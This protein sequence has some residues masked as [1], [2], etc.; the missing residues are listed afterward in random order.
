[1]T[2]RSYLLLRRAILVGVVSSI[3]FGVGFLAYRTGTSVPGTEVGAGKMALVLMAAV[4]AICGYL[5][6]MFRLETNTGYSFA[7]TPRLFRSKGEPGF[8]GQEDYSELVERLPDG[9]YPREQTVPVNHSNPVKL[10]VHGKGLAGQINMAANPPA[11]LGEDAEVAEELDALARRYPVVSQLLSRGHR[12]AVELMDT[13]DL[14]RTE[15]TSHR[16]PDGTV[17]KLHVRHAP[18]LVGMVSHA[19]GL[20]MSFAPL[21]GQDEGLWK[22][23]LGKMS[24]QLGITTLEVRQDGGRMVLAFNDKI[25]DLK[26]L[27]KL[28]EPLRVQVSQGHFRSPLGVS[29]FGDVAIDWANN[30][31]MVA[32]GVPG[33]GKT[34]SMLPVFAGL[35][36]RVEMHIADGKLSEDLRSMIPICRTFDNEGGYELGR[37]YALC[38]SIMFMINS[39]AR[40]KAIY[41]SLGIANFWNADP[42]AREAAGLYPIFVNIDECQFWFDPGKTLSK[43][44]KAA[45]DSIINDVKNMIQRGRSLGIMVVLTTQKP[46][47]DTIPTSIRDIAGL[48]IAFRVTTRDQGKAI[49]GTLSSD[50]ASPIAI[51]KEIKGRCVMDVEG[52]GSSL[53]QTNYIDPDEIESWLSNNFAPVPDQF[54]RAVGYP[55]AVAMQAFHDG[56]DPPPPMVAGLTPEAGRMAIVDDDMMA[57]MSSYDAMLDAPECTSE[58][59][60]MLPVSQPPEPDAE[61]EE[62][63]AAPLPEGPPAA[64][65]TAPVPAESVRPAVEPREQTPAAPAPPHDRPSVAGVLP[66]A[67]PE[68][69]KSSAPPDSYALPIPAPEVPR[70]PPPMPPPAG[71]AYPLPPH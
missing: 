42:A 53:V 57:T 63:D 5:G 46:T 19:R 8:D 47:A 34:A 69:G 49:L 68:T 61:R 48:K 39:R 4:A 30:S 11:L 26:P 65:P 66:A 60:A 45:T 64:P 12:A 3:V 36:G 37:L 55:L 21:K 71:P 27:M 9:R 6:Y 41:D 13:A 52:V 40:A 31:G 35:A 56:V 43:E 22:R 50:Q 23:S 16:N 67:S 25:T 14:M 10:E 59:Q 33:S 38:R 7:D 24:T 29:A 62:S 20:V 32:G 15:A 44:D 28:D 70:R 58:G 18:A 1:M 17:T 51:P 54:A 2:R